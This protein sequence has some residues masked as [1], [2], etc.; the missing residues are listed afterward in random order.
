MHSAIA[1]L[2]AEGPIQILVN[3]AGIHRDA[4]MAGMDAD[5]WDSVIDTSLNGFFRVTQPLLLPMVRTRWGRIINITSVSA[6]AG[7]K[8]QAN[9]AAAKAGLHGATKSLALEL[10]GR[11]I[12][13]N[14]VAPGI[15]QTAMID[16]GLSTRADQGD[17]ADGSRRDGRGSGGPGGLPGLR[18]SELHHRPDHRCQRR[19]VLSMDRSGTAARIS[20]DGVWIAIP[21]YNEEGTIRAL[22]QKAL[23]LCPRVMV[24]DDG[25][26]DATARRNWRVCPSRCCAQPSNRGK[27]ARLR[28]AFAEALRQRAA[29][30]VTLDGDGQHDPND[31][32]ALLRAWRQHPDRL[33]VGSRLHDKAQFP[34]ARYRANRF[35]CFWISW[36]AGHPIA[37]SQS[38]FRVYPAAVIGASLSGERCAATA[39]RSKARS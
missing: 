5:T 31:A 25:S 18:R 39:S 37:D 6:Q 12:T 32:P 30:V 29:C 26:T 11:G 13:V 36:A 2:L 16:D 22:A 9:Y 8:G 33:I 4:L 34:L 23:A 3:N 24:V 10:A 14:A 15:I 21:A 27:A 17:G 35:A 1:A 19:A 7:N 38:G 28:L 20:W